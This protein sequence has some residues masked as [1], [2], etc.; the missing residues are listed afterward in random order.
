[1]EIQVVN[2]ELERGC[3]CNKGLLNLLMY[4]EQDCEIVEKT[5]IQGDLER[6]LDIKIGRR[7]LSWKGY[8]FWFLNI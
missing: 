2:P 1:M 8:I 7:F 6:L 5:E 4:A 3:N